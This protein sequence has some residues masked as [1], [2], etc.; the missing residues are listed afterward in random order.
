MTGG[1]S[2]R[3]QSNLWWNKDCEETVRVKRKMYRLYSKD[4]NAESHER[5][6]SA[7]RNCNKIIARAERDH[8]LASLD[9]VSAGKADLGSVW[10]KMR[11]MKRQYVAPDSDLQRGSRVY[12]TDQAKADVSWKP[13]LKPVAPTVSPR[14]CDSSDV[15]WM[16]LSRS[17]RR[18]I[19]WRATPH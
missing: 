8:W 4:Q 9:S 3:P 18:T 19:V 14:T 17:R 6:K 11:K 16:L 13:A 1:G 5:M 7:N 15:R 10:K 12:T 2:S